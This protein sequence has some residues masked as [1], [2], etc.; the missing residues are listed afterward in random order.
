[1][2][3]IAGNFRGR[4][5]ESVRDLSVRPTTDRA[6]QT[7]FDILTNRIDFD[8]LE[9]LDLFAGSGS[10]GL[11]AISRGAKSVTFIDKSMKSLTVL[12]KNVAALKCEAQC[13]VYQAD[14]FWYLKNMKRTYNLVF[15]DPPYK[16]ENIG[17]LPNAIY[18]SGIVQ[19][20]SYVVMEHSRESVIE[21]DERKYNILKKP[22][23]QTTVLILKAI[24][25]PISPRT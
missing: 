5:L 13:S 24:V 10:L 3:I 20:G 4:S 8:G 1:M 19:N 18:D 7:I 22:F 15:A 17:V 11:E 16:L 23:G 6:K 25:P 2:R 21:L 14:V 12:E 9:V